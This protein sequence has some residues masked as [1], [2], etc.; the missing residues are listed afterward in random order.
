M[1]LLCTR[2]LPWLAGYVFLHIFD[3]HLLIDSQK[4]HY[5]FQVTGVFCQS[6]IE[7]AQSDHAADSENPFVCVQFITVVVVWQKLPGQDFVGCTAH[8]LLASIRKLSVLVFA[9]A[10]R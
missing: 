3:T 5:N 4:S 2:S 9:K 6:A 10:R 1:N 7:S 8:C